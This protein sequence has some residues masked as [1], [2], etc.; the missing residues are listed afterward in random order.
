MCTTT[1]SFFY[2]VSHGVFPATAYPTKST[3]GSYGFKFWPVNSDQA[4]NTLLSLLLHLKL[5]YTL[6]GCLAATC[7]TAD[8]CLVCWFPC[9][10]CRLDPSLLLPGS[11][12]CTESLIGMHMLSP[13]PPHAGCLALCWVPRCQGSS[14]CGSEAPC[15]RL[16][17]CQ[18]AVARHPPHSI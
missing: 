11:L 17:M 15:M 18:Q 5:P 6:V 14:I 10:C 8:G 7:L 4:C 13:L 3:S 2:V 9:C 12:S 1:S 16:E